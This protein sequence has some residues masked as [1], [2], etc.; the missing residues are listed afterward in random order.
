[1]SE[2]NRTTEHHDF[3]RTRA[4][5]RLYRTLTSGYWPTRIGVAYQVRVAIRSVHTMPWEPHRPLNP[6]EVY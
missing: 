1:M 6:T 2:A 4:Q 5:M 3:C